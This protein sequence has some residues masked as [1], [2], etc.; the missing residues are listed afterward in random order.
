MIKRIHQKFER[1]RNPA[2]CARTRG[3]AALWL[4]CLAFKFLMGPP[5]SVSVTDILVLRSNSELI[6]LICLRC[7][8]SKI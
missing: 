1:D 2:R 3:A 7:L 6:N 8:I 4:A 5:V